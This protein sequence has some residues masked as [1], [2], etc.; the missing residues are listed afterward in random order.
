MLTKLVVLD[1]SRN[2]NITMDV[3]PYLTV[4]RE[5]YLD[6]SPVFAE[7]DARLYRMSFKLPN[8]K[9]IYWKKYVQYYWFD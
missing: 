1:I 5:L 4:L 3:L 6:S 2:K 8:L 7:S 9:N